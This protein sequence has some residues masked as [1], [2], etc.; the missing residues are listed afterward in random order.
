[1]PALTLRRETSIGALRAFNS[2]PR[3]STNP[4]LLPT[5]HSPAG[6]SLAS[7]IEPL[8]PIR[9]P[10][11]RSS[12][13]KTPSPPRKARSSASSSIFGAFVSALKGKKRVGPQH[14]TP[15]RADT[16]NGHSAA[17]LRKMPS[18][19]GGGTTWDQR[20]L[21]RRRRL[22]VPPSPV[23]YDDMDIDMAVGDDGDG[24]QHVV[25]H[26]G[27]LN[28]ASSS[29]DPFGTPPWT[30]TEAG[31]RAPPLSPVEMNGSPDSVR[32]RRRRER[33]RSAVK[34]L[35]ILGVEA[36]GAVR[37]QYGQAWEV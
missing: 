23:K 22:L 26:R 6:S 27:M 25:A 9:P 15:P 36:S 37:Q 34:S 13:K 24:A 14:R 16:R 33:E 19:P 20:F 21:Q 12:P 7:L 3:S 30:P 28:F 17:A 32:S 18:C 4:Y 31:M 8:S 11:R 29:P 35:Q 1:M 10:S 5:F 2:L